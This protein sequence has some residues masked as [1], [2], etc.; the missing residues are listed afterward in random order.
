MDSLSNETS[1][2]YKNM[3]LLIFTLPANFLSI[4]SETKQAVLVA[5]ERFNWVFM[6]GALTM[7][8]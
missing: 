7:V 8:I 2:M 5:T 1:D 6:I 4:F 3:I